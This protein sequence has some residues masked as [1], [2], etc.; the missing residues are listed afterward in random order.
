M[1]VAAVLGVVED[2]ARFE[3]HAHGQ[4]SARFDRPLGG[5]EIDFVPV[6]P[7]L[8]RLAVDVGREANAEALL[9][10]KARDQDACA[11]RKIRSVFPKRPVRGVVVRSDLEFLDRL[12]SRTKR[13]R[14]IAPTSARSRGIPVR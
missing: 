11:A 5:E 3:Q 7:C 10:V 12:N 4:R 14:V 8:E 9:D 13:R 6:F 2:F 1:Q